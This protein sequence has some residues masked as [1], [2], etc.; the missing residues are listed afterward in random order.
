MDPGIFHLGISSPPKFI[1]N[2]V[3]NHTS[4][5][6][7]CYG[8]KVKPNTIETYLFKKPSILLLSQNGIRGLKI[9][10]DQFNL[11]ANYFNGLNF[12]TVGDRTHQ[13]LM[14]ELKIDSKFPEIMTGKG[15]IHELQRI[16]V[17]NI[18]LISSG[19]AVFETFNI[20]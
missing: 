19:V 20:S 12:W 14:K 10:L 2:I 16:G 3:I 11:N 6:E 17:T 4:V 15:L 9:W 7:I 1:S 18:F 8:T 13:F 5:I